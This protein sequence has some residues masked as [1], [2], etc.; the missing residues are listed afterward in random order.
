MLV[1]E[2]KIGAYGSFGVIESEHKGGER[3]LSGF[4]VPYR[5]LVAIQ[6]K[7]KIVCRYTDQQ[8]AAKKWMYEN[9]L[10]VDKDKGRSSER[11]FTYLSESGY[12]TE[13][14]RQADT[15]EDWPVTTLI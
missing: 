11:S 12:L 5:D 13:L 7:N 4:A 14:N 15:V 3:F 2:K 10:D 1:F 9:I 6:A 8:T